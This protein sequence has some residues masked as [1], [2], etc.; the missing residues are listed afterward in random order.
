MRRIVIVILLTFTSIV[1]SFSQNRTITLPDRPKRG[2]YVDY[3]IKDS[4]WWCAAQ[5]NGGVASTT[6]A[7]Y[8]AVYQV[9]FVNG[10]RFSEFLKVGIGVSPRLYGGGN[11]FPLREDGRS[12]VY[13]LPIYVDLRGNIISQA[14]TMFA[15][16][17]NVDLGYSINEGIYLSPCVGMKFG[18]IRHN[19]I[20]GISYGLQ[21]HKT[22]SYNKPIHLL[23]LKAG[24]EF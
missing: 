16:Y 8:S 14:D 10:Y 13:S 7:H 24:Y 4:G 11:G 12:I 22:E 15:P 23:G 17:W 3:S 19:F 18:G 2:Q 1:S 9:D 5:L 21:G 6:D 20:V